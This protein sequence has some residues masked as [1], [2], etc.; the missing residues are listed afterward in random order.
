MKHHMKW[1]M[2]MGAGLALL[3][4]VVA[5][6]A[7][8]IGFAPGVNPANPQDLIN[9]SNPQDLLAPG[10]YNRQDLVR[11]SPGA[12]SGV[13]SP[14][15][16]T[17]P[18][19]TGRYTG[20]QT[21]RTAKAKKATSKQAKR[22]RKSSVRDAEYPA[23]RMSGMRPLDL[24]RCACS[25]AVGASVAVDISAR[26]RAVAGAEVSARGQIVSRSPGKR[27]PDERSDIR[28]RAKQDFG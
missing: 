17:A 25:H 14:S 11:P 16:V 27:S 6:D 15:R 9:R 7:Q 22:Q 12:R 10:G 13:T 20:Q 28:D 2:V 26:V 19:Y 3:A 5:A 21:P 8:G 1:V 24:R 23:S 4:G 18:G